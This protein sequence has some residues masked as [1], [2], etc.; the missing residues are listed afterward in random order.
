VPLFPE[1]RKELQTL[2]DLVEGELS[3]KPKPSEEPI[4]ATYRT[5]NTN[6]RTRLYRIIRRAGLTPWPKLFQNLRA[7]RATE[8]TAI[9]PAHVAT[10]WLG[11]STLI[12]YKHY[13]QVTDA[14]FE[15]ATGDQAAKEK[16]TH[17]QTLYNAVSGS[18]VQDCCSS[19]PHE[20]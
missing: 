12:V 4:I 10:A 8:L 20:F 17:N 15:N 9:H 19:H 2:W 6:L 1:V 14:D 11:H 18:R 16:A 3:Q 13:W 5:A 7:S